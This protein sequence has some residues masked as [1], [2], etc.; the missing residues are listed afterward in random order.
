M[1]VRPEEITSIIRQ[2]IEQFG[3]QVAA[4]DVGTVVE[5]GDGIARVHGLQGAMY[6]EILEFPE[7]IM[8][9]ALNLEEDTV[10]AMILGDHTKIREGD[11]VR[12]TGRIVQVPVGEALI[13]RVVDPLGNPLDGKGP[14]SRDKTRAVE[15]I[16][17]NVVM[18]KSVDT[19]VQTGIKAI[20][21]MIPIGR[22]QRE[23]IIGDRSTGKIGH[24]PGHHH[25]PEGRR[26]HLHLRAPSARRRPRWRRWWPRWS[27]TGPWR[28][29]SW[30]RPTPPT[31][32]PC[33]TWRPTPACAMGEEFMEQGRRRPGRLRR[34][35]ASTPGP[36]ARYRC[37]CGGPPAAR[38]TRATSSTCTAVSWSGRPSWPPSTAA[39]P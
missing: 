31:R 37:C 30:W 5:S 1:A 20:D 33:S 28:T 36:I 17:P 11:E 12:A 10:G 24:R 23:L 14:I 15:R 3:V 13:G 4:V 34:P 19:P 25:Q 26:P 18:R 29:P 38:P 8:G 35:D 32:R 39:A 21:S 7:D 27:S 16:A 2:Q 6:N 22:G 9:L